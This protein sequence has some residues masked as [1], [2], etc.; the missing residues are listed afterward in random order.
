MAGN[1][2]V[3][4]AILTLVFLVSGAAQE[5]EYLDQNWSAGLREQFY[6]T[7]QGSLLIPYDW[8]LALERADDRE[9]FSSPANLSRFGWLYHSNASSNLNPGN[10]PIGMTLEPAAAPGGGNWMGMTCAACHT[11]NVVFQGKTIRVSRTPMLF[12]ER[13]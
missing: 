5:V 4:A 3:L 9:L 11:G 7:P 10:L 1:R 2:A 8:F 12:R 6:F 13:P